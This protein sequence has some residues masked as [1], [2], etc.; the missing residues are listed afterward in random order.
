MKDHLLNGKEKN[1]DE[2]KNCIGG[3]HL[4]IR[5]SKRK[6]FLCSL[7]SVIAL[8]ITASLSYAYFTSLGE[9]NRQ[10]ATISAGTVS[11]TFAD[12]TLGITKELTFGESITK[13]FTI[14]NTG[15]VDATVKMYFKDLINTYGLGSLTY[16]LSQSETENGPYT[17]I[18]NKTDVPKSIRPS[19]KKLVEP[20]VIPVGKTYY[21]NLE[22][23]LNYLSDVNQDADIDAKFSTSFELKDINEEEPPLP[24]LMKVTSTYNEK[25]WAHRKDIKRIVF[26]M[27]EEPKEDATYSYDLSEAQN[28]SIMSYLVPDEEDNTKYIAYIQSDD[29]ISLNEDSSYLFYNFTNLEEIE[30][31]KF[32]DTSKVINMASMFRYCQKLSSLDLS[33]FDTS[34]VTNMRNMF[35]YCSNLILLNINNFDTSNVIDMSSMFQFCTSLNSLDLSEFDTSSV[36]NMSHMFDWCHNIKRLN[37]N[38]FDT[39][40]VTNMANMFFCCIKLEVVDL[41]SFDTSNVTNMNAMFSMNGMTSSFIELDLSNFDTSKVTNMSSMFNACTSLISLDLSNFNTSNVTT[42]YAMFSWC[43]NLTSLNLSKFD[44][45]KVKEMSYMFRNCNKL[46]NLNLKNWNINK[47]VETTDNFRE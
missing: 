31:I 39:S 22:I 41:S 35:Y 27:A 46:A 43:L 42:M 44:T 38:N 4:R 29:K 10:E 8:V 33:S 3:S 9:T 47:V 21:Y 37:L 25:L 45:S 28:G 24:T 5:P 40:K 2:Q 12:G 36:T 34:K 13:S 6:V 19:L 11:A 20:L 26:E 7:L 1:M 15:T 23:S 30:N 18:V 32:L 17:E 14:T 16:T